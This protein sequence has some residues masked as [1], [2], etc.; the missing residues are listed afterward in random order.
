MSVF[1]VFVCLCWCVCVSVSVSLSLC[2]CVRV[3]VC[4]CV[5]MF[6]SHQKCR[7]PIPSPPSQ[8]TVRSRDHTV[9]YCTIVLYSTKIE[10]ICRQTDNQTKN[11][12]TFQKLSPL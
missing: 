9:L 6:I 5:S 1:S 7:H 10:K 12:Q 2:F 3:F 8:S 11:K 4:V